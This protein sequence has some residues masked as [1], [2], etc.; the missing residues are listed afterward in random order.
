MVLGSAQEAIAQVAETD[1]AAQLSWRDGNLIFRGESL[2]QALAEITRYTSV[3]FEVMD[4][5]IKQERIA[6]LFKAGDVDGL[7]AT[8]TRNFNIE[9]ERLDDNKILLRAR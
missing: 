4:E 9:S 1:I 2:E 7:L 3:E 5:R 8:L 6:G